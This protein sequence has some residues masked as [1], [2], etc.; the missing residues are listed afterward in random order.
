MLLEILI[1]VAVVIGMTLIGISLAKVVGMMVQ[2]LQPYFVKCTV[3]KA[4]EWISNEISGQVIIGTINND[5]IR[6]RAVHFPN[7]KAVTIIVGKP[8]GIS[9]SD[10]MSLILSPSD[11]IRAGTIETDLW[12]ISFPPVV[13]RINVYLKR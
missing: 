3:Y 7:Q 1:A 10:G 9:R 4:L 8:V 5:R 11:V 2:N 12:A 6:I 13:A